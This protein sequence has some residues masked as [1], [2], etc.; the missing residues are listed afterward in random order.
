MRRGVS[1]VICRRWLAVLCAIIAMLGAVQGV[2]AA[3]AALDLAMTQA[4]RLV[5][6]AGTSVLAA[7]ASA[8]GHWTF[9][10][11]KG[12]RFTAATPD[13]MTRMTG[14]LAPESKAAGAKLLLVV[15]EASV[16]GNAEVLG[17]LP[18]DAAVRLSTATGVY[19][20]AGSPPRQVQISP[21]LRA[22]IGERSA[23]DEVLLQLDKSLAKGGIR[24]LALD[25]SGP[26]ALPRRLAIDAKSKGDLV[27]RVD[28]LRL[29]DALAGFSGQTVVA[30]GRLEGKFLQFQVAGGPDRSLVADDLIAAA[31]AADAN[32][33]I[34]D[35]AAGRQPGARNWLW[36]RAELQG[37][38]ALHP[39]SGLD[40]LLGAFGSQARPLSVRLTRLDPDR[41]TMIAVPGAAA[42]PSTAGAIGEALGRVA[43]D[44]TSGVTGRI[45]PTAIHMHLV[46]AARSRELDRR[47]IRWLPAWATW[48]YLGLL[49]LGALGSPV[50]RRWWGQI[51]PPET[52]AD[53][54]NATGLQAAKAVR[55]VA[56]ALVFMPAVALVAVPMAV[57]SMMTRTSKGQL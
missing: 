8:E 10:N 1:A 36:L 15:T 51:W 23:F 54:P 26:A 53:Y 34:L 24:V 29:K 55:G 13:E 12:E 9:V 47:L 31:A 25:P 45:E 5:V 11:A 27:E 16:F 21:K 46:S 14:V 44:L 43:A 30:T 20:L 56:Y 4:Q 57:A 37:A 3:D 49:L 40:A 19:A 41:V 38:D 32:L 18:R 6:P 2:R 7:S 35:A 22:E 33:I 28:P 42:P 52:A 48:G 50:S 39:D 17:K